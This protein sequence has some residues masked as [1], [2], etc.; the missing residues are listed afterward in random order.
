M[1]QELMEILNDVAMNSVNPNVSPI[2][3][4]FHITIHEDSTCG[5]LAEDGYDEQNLNA[6]L[7][8]VNMLATNHTKELKREIEERLSGQQRHV[9]K[10]ELKS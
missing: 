6:M 3:R 7:S 5:Y 8:I 10:T 9:S 4:V 1:S 2:S